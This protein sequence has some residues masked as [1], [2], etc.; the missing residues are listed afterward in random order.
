MIYFFGAIVD[1]EEGFAEKGR[2]IKNFTNLVIDITVQ[3]VKDF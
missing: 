1:F 2:K 3:I